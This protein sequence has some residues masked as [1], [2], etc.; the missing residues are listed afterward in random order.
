MRRVRFRSAGWW[1]AMLAVLAVTAWMS[2]PAPRAQSAQQQ[3]PQRQQQEQQELRDQPPATGGRLDTPADELRATVVRLPLAAV[4][5]TIL[6]L[7]PRRRSTPMRQMPVV[8]TQI[9]LA[10]VG[11]L[12][13]LVVGASL[14]RAFGIVG[15]AN[16]IR[17]R[18][19]VD[20][21][22]DAVVM[23]SA[24]GVGLAS[25]VGLYVLAAAGTLLIGIA[26]WTIEGFEPAVRKRFELSVGFKD[27]VVELQPRIEAILR[28]YHA[29]YEIRQSSADTISY[30]ITAPEDLRLDRVSQAMTGLAGEGE[31]SVEWD[32]QKTKKG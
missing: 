19:K 4:L 12:V 32:Q 30:A 13:M 24:L 26:L 9:V 5:G 14:A 18:A 31:I 1:A 28:R 22:K 25:G 7:R 27:K 20:D 17:Y 29:K 11:A 2:A 21:P 8:E 3:Q 15:A 16:L 6:A 23:L 10:M